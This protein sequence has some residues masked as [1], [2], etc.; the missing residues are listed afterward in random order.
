[1]LVTMFLLG[2]VSVVLIGVALSAGAGIAPVLVIAAVFFAIQLVASDKIALAAIGAREV[3]P[4]QAPDLHAI[5][6]RLCVQADLPKPRVAVSTRRCHMHVRW[7]PA[8]DGY[9]LRHDQPPGAAVAGAA[10][11]LIVQETG[12]LDQQVTELESE[13]EKLTQ[14]EK[15]LQTKIEEFRS[16]K[17]VIKGEYSAAEAEVWINEAATEVG[18]QMADVG[19]AMQRA[20]DNTET[21][22]ARASAVEE[23]QAAGTFEDLTALGPGQDD[24]DRELEQLGASSAVDDELAKLKAELGPGAE[25][26]QIDAGGQPDQ[27]V[28]PASGEPSA[29]R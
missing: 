22:K 27:S 2:Q 23:L 12:T 7:A 1:M 20:I 29:D 6:E 16:K 10:R 26:G 19:L 28:E 8:A 25:P 21:L 17:E 18:D 5:T 11:G 9:R 14:A 4:A 15:R 3:S 13:Q 24:V